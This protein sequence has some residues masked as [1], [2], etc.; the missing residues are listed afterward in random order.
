MQQPNLGQIFQR[1]DR[2]RSG[3]ISAEELQSALSNG[4]WSPFNP[5]T[6]RLMIGMFDS[7]GD[8]AINFGEFQALWQ[9]VNEWT[10]CFRSFDQDNSGAIDHAELTQ[11]LTK[12]GYRLSP[13]F[14]G[15]LVQKFD[16]THKNSVN[17]DDFIQLCVVLQTLTTSFRDKD[18]DRDGIIT[19]GYEEFLKMVFSLKMALMSSD[20]GKAVKRH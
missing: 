14:I 17:F 15:I 10:R 4:T 13:D 1:V 9:Y 18:T 3:K 12:F 8:G 11:A 16:R 5:E 20:S 6:C 19:V 7:D 2:D